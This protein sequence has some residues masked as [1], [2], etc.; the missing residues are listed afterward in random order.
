MS[1]AVA[2]S[3]TAVDVGQS[4]V[5]VPI[6]RATRLVFQI[7]DGARIPSLDMAWLS[8]VV[9]RDASGSPI[10]PELAGFLEG[11]GGRRA[12]LDV[13]TLGPVRVELP[14]AG[15]V[16]PFEPIE[17]VVRGEPEVLVELGPGER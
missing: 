6:S 5:V 13:A 14:A 2:T 11:E 4:V 8:S 17:V 3:S 9:L 16:H 1:S 12:F 7:A 15:G 10:Q